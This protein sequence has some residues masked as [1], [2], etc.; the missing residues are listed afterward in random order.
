MCSSDLIGLLTYLQ[1][2]PS[3]SMA[4]DILYIQ[5]KEKAIFIQ[6][7]TLLHERKEL[8][9]EKPL[10]IATDSGSHQ[11]QGLFR[12]K[13]LLSYAAQHGIYA[14]GLWNVNEILLNAPR[15]LNQEIIIGPPQGITITTIT[16]G[17]TNA[18]AI[19]VDNPGRQ[20]FEKILMIYPKH[21]Y[22]EIIPQ[23]A[24]TRPLELIPFAT[25]NLV[26]DLT[27]RYKIFS[28]S[29]NGKY[30]LAGEDQSLSVKI[31]EQSFKGSSLEMDPEPSLVLD[32][33]RKL[34]HL[35]TIVELYFSPSS[36]SLELELTPNDTFSHHTHN[37]LWE[38][39][40]QRQI[41]YDVITDFTFIDPQLLIDYGQHLNLEGR[42]KIPDI[43][44]TVYYKALTLLN[45]LCAE[46]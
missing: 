26:L 33:E 10:V 7:L 36:H 42:N 4:G 45:I 12:R 38:W 27:R 23:G 11:L 18:P 16:D 30:N 35:D 40:R 29:A 9:A 19:S 8:I 15:D 34:D 13:E 20:V 28:F 32:C 1:A 14:D 17:R 37:V 41:G 31:Y 2:R 6:L 22:I 24:E 25:E 44:K 5:A 43:S 46:K 21:F 3:V 39:Q